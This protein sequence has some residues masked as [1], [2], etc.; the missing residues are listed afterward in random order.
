MERVAVRRDVLPKREP[1]LDL[2]LGRNA[3]SDVLQMLLSLFA[4][5]LLSPLFVLIAIAIRLT[6][7]GPILY[8]GERVGQ[9]ERSFTMYKFRTLTVGAE[10]EIGARLLKEEDQVYAP[11]GKFLKKWKL[12]EIPQLLNVLK[13]DMRLVGPRPIRPVFLETFRKVIPNYTLRFRLK[14]GLTGLAQLRGGYWTEP[15]DKLRYELVYIKNRTL[16][17]DLKLIGL[18]FLKIFNR[19]VTTSVAL[20][21]LFLFV[22]FFPTSMHRWLYVTMW[23]FRLNLLYLLIVF[24][25]IWLVVK[26]TYTHRLF[27]YRSPIYWPMAGFAAVGFASA[28][29]SADPETAIR[30]TTY[31]LVTGFLV[32]STLL[33]TRLSAKFV[34][35]AA[36]L[37][38][39]VCGVLSLVGLFELALIKHSVLA[40][41]QGAEA[42][43]AASA[44]AIKATFANSNVLSAYLVLGFPLLLCQ[45]IH[46]QT[47]S[48][49]DF[50]LVATTIAFTSILLTQNLLGL[51]AL[52]VA[53]AVFLAYASSRTVPLLICVFLIPVLILGAWD[54]SATPVRAYELLRTKFTNE[55]RVLAVVP[56]HQLVLGAGPKTLH[57]RPES[58]P[59]RQPNGPESASGNMHLA[60]VLETG[61]LGWLLM[62]G[63]FWAVLRTFYRGARQARD[64][65]QRSLLWAIF[66]SAIGFLISMS[67]F[68]VFFHIPLQV[69]FWG[70]VGLGLGIVT[71]VIGRRS[72]F[73]T[74]WRFGDERPRPERKRSSANSAPQQGFAL[75]PAR[76]AAGGRLST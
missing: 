64:P 7:S 72:P 66:S 55:I 12:D 59:I 42:M 13:G 60:L 51:V 45:L 52:F 44:W 10:Q 43:G 3:V 40:N 68:D 73:Y 6:S 56:P 58:A 23:G 28:I 24:F 36:T 26:K 63:I 33:N 38:G 50:W 67:G 20:S 35:S 34:R 32:T 15:R 48:G 47:R 29:F 16:L 25:G 4:L 49:R 22:S 61:I 18:T 62:L 53:S 75:D 30:G 65:Y 37:V 74:I 69:L 71:H 39:F 46:T 17:L 14:P 2:P 27:I 41:A 57:P 19:F 21:A 54:E 8:R 5:V 11:I 31:Y 1:I 9:D 76:E 70:L